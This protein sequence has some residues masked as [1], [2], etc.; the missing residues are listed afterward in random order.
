MGGGGGGECWQLRQVHVRRALLLYI[1]Q[2]RAQDGHAADISA[3][4]KGC[5]GAHS[6]PLRPQVVVAKLGDD[7]GHNAADRVTDL[8]QGAAEGERG[9]G[10]GVPA[11][12]S[13]R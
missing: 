12:F 13:V 5:C 7:A 11:G 6:S 9:G 3:L 1:K 4:R 10:G 8:V 2:V